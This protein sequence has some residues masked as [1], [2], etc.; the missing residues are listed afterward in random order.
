MSPKRRNRNEWD[1]TVTEVIACPKNPNI[2]FSLNT[3]INEISNC[4]KILTLMMLSNPT[5]EMVITTEHVPVYTSPW[6]AQP[7]FKSFFFQ[8]LQMIICFF[9]TTINT[10]IQI[11]LEDINVKKLTSNIWL[12][13]IYIYVQRD[14][15]SL[16]LWRLVYNK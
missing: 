8:K 3:Q 15:I 6:T 4:H 9:S 12:Q 13:L 5:I 14:V 11:I 16:R 1:L 2:S 10:D 7:A